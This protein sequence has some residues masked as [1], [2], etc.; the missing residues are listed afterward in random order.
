M[1]LAEATCVLAFYQRPCYLTTLV[2]SPHTAGL[3]RANIQMF[4]YQV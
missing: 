3:Q 1:V 2:I 4:L